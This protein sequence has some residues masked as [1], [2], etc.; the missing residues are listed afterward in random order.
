MR[1]TTFRFLTLLC[2]L[3]VSHMSWAQQSF[4]P[5]P[6]SPWLGLLNQRDGPLDNYNRFVRP[7]MELDR[8]LAAQQNAIMQSQAKGASLQRQIDVGASMLMDGQ[9]QN[10]MIPKTGT[11]SQAAQHRNFSHYYPNMN[12]R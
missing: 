7:R 5:A 12:R 8:A 2:V 6:L 4:T 9:Q 10:S 1:K 11:R 3:A